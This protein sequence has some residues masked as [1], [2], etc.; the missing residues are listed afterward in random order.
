MLR[1]VYVMWLREVKKFQRSRSRIVGALAQPVLYLLALGYGLG[2]VFQ[3]AGQGSYVQF[4][5]PGIISM[6]IAFT[7]VFNG[8][9]IIWDRQFGFLKETL[10]APVPRGAIMLGRTL[11]GATI[12]TFQGCIVLALT[13][14]FGFHPHS[15]ALVLPAIAVMFL[16]AMVCSAL[17][18]VVASHLAD[19]QGFQFV[20]NFLV[21]PMFFLSGALFPLA[22]SPYPLRALATFDPLS[23]GVDGMR[24]L[25][26][27]ISHYGAATDVPVLFAIAILLLG[28]GSHRFARMEA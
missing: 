23:Y 14:A 1:T 13:L 2:G 16:V 15:W 12:A 19:M 8:M 25:L 26:S 6:T 22:D 9:Q 5:V 11:G 28:L 27:N 4:L 24:S 7:A 21:T 18:I 17:G 20:V 3:A 10:V